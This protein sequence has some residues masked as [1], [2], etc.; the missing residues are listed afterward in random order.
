M[1]PPLVN[2][3]HQKLC[4]DGHK[5]FDDSWNVS[6]RKVDQEEKDRI[7]VEESEYYAENSNED[8]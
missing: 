3:Y 4:I 7:S 2:G 6:N 5:P 1:L 8:S